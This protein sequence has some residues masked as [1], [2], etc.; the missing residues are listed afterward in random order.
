MPRLYRSA[1]DLEHWFVFDDSTG[2]QKF[3]ARIDGW[4][5][6]RPVRTVHGLDLREVPLWLSFHT[7]LP[8]AARRLGHA[9]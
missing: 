5:Q 2:W 3:P 1:K 9:A 8:L 6:R 4:A 7:G